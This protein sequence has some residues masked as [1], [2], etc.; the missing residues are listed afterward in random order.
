MIDNIQAI[1][2]DVDGVLVDSEQTHFLA[3]QKLLLEYGKALTWQDYKKYFSGKSIRGGVEHYN[4]DH[5]IGTEQDFETLLKVISEKKINSTTKL[6][7][8][9]ID[10]FNDTVSFIDRIAVG[11]LSLK[12][13]GTIREKPTLAFATGMEDKLMKEVLKHNDLQNKIST[14][15]T[16]GSYKKSKP[17]PECYL[18]ALQKIKMSAD[19]VI[20]V[21]DSPAGI[22]AL[23]AAGIFSI[24]LTTSHSASELSKAKVIVSTLSE[25]IL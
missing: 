19:Q 3:Y 5:H 22:D 12:D 11:N 15:V 21:E 8:S 18:V 25:L 6:F 16:P 13:I 20:G 4:K 24:G 14:V 17:D 10:F 1:I 7:E 2:F 9:H 23:N